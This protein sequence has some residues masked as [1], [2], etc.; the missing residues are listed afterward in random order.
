M[1]GQILTRINEL[2]KEIKVL[3]SLSKKE[4][5]KSHKKSLLI[6]IWK[7][8]K[9]DDK[10]LEKAKKAPFDFDVEKYVRNI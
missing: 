7:G 9:I 1:N 4:G 2:E 10:D 5:K 6:G 3:K 8:L